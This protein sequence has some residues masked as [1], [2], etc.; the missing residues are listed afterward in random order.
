MQLQFNVVSCAG[1]PVGTLHICAIS[2]GRLFHAVRKPDGSS[3]PFEDVAA[4]VTAGNPGSP[5]PA[6]VAS[7]GCAVVNGQ[8]NLVSVDSAGMLWHVI[9]RANGAWQSFVTMTG[10][11]A[12]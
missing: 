10:S 12:G 11:A 6:D 5:T 7:V 3:S 8:L 4:A 2:S 1:S 9:R